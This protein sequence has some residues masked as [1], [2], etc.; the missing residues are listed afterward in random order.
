MLT[1]KEKQDNPISQKIIES[2]RRKFNSVRPNEHKWSRRDIK[3]GMY[4]EIDDH[5]L[6]RKYV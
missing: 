6:E 3:V 2:N 5:F 1:L 4:V